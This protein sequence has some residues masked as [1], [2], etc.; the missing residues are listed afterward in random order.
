MKTAIELLREK[1]I[2]IGADG[3]CHKDLIC[4]CPA[5]EILDWC[6]GISEFCIPAK[7]NPQK[8]AEMETAFWMEPMN[9]LSTTKDN[10]K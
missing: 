4:A 7:N 10:E 6:D 1:L 2:E 9:L 8:A 3:L 5:P